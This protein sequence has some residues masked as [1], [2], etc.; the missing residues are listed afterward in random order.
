MQIQ[1]LDIP[2]VI[3]ITPKKFGDHRGFFAE[4]YSRKT[5]AAAGIDVEFVQDNHSLSA[6]PGTVRALHFQLP[7][8]AQDK[9]VRVL[10]GSI[11]DV[12][13][14]IRRGSPTFGKFVT[15]TLTAD[16]M[17][18]FF[19]PI[20][21]AHGF[22]TLEPNT[23]VAYKVTNYYAPTHERGILWNDPAIGIPWGVAESEATLSG[24]DKVAP[25]LKDVAELF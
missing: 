25:L 11:L 8:F 12:A 18:M 21:F 23:E 1:P 7:P 14:D 16:G 24:K 15:A 9:L 22:V 10:K 3:L 4:T 19:V 6:T 2:D 13:V 17:Q 5:L 20:G